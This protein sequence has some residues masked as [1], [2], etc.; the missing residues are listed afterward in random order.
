MPIHLGG[1]R[2]SYLVKLKYRLAITGPNLNKIN[3]R[4]VG[5][6]NPHP[7]MAS[8]KLSRR[9]KFN[10]LCIVEAMNGVFITPPL[11]QTLRVLETLRVWISMETDPE[12]P[13]FIS[14]GRLEPFTIM[15]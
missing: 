7:Q 11:I 1:L 15:R 8:S 14:T 5:M 13:R 12:L 9:K 3:P 2:I 4:T 10:L 6:I